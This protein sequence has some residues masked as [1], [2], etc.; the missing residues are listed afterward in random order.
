MMDIVYLKLY[1]MYHVTA[2]TVEFFKQSCKLVHQNIK[3]KHEFD[4]GFWYNIHS[5]CTTRNRSKTETVALVVQKELC[6]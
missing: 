4:C 3:K 2:P 6:T 1:N 5:Y